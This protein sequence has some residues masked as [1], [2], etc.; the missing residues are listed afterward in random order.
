MRLRSPIVL[1]R[2]S[3]LSPNTG[4]SSDCARSP[5]PA[6]SVTIVS[7]GVA[8]TA[9]KKRSASANSSSGGRRG[10][11]DVHRFGR[12][13][14]RAAFRRD[15]APPTDASLRPRTS[16]SRAS[17]ATT[18]CRIRASTEASRVVMSIVVMRTGSHS[19]AARATGGVNGYIQ[20]VHGAITQHLCGFTDPFRRHWED[21]HPFHIFIFVRPLRRHWRLSP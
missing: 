11:G 10:A 14:D 19:R 8:S 17:Y 18:C 13:V 2:P 5:R 16:R 3:R 9:L 1:T 15:N 21:L 12:G 6:A 4:R 20:T 7:P